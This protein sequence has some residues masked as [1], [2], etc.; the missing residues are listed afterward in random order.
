MA[1]EFSEDVA[2]VAFGGEGA[3]DEPAGDLVVVQAAGDQAQDVAFPVGE[4]RQCGEW[5]L[6]VAAGGELGDEPAGNPG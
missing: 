1:V 5:L 2:D 4:V 3:D 6:G